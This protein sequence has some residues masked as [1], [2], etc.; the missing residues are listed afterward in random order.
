MRGERGGRR[1]AEAAI[2]QTQMRL[3]D[4]GFLS[5]LLEACLA[6]TM[7]PEKEQAEPL[8]DDRGK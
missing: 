3:V 8:V 1:G 7:S 6:H 2:T 5:G 4:Y